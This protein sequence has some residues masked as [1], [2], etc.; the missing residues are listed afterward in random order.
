MKRMTYMSTFSRHLS[1]DDISEIGSYAARRNA[2]DG[3]TGV[4][5]TLLVA[6]VRLDREADALPVRVEDHVRP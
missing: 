6:L 1:P 5:L 2:H 4:L 3:V